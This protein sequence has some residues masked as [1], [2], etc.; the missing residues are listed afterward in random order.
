MELEDEM[1]KDKQQLLEEFERRRKARQINV[2]TDDNEVRRSLRQL[3]EPVCL[4]G[5]G[6]AERR[7]RLRDLL[8]LYVYLKCIENYVPNLFILYLA[9]AKMPSIRRWKR[10]KRGYNRNAARKALGIMKDLQN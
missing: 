8:S 10:K 7:A 1:S 4:F 2:S 9:L 3:G 6:P 5:E